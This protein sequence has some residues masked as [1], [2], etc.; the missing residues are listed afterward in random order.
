MAKENTRYDIFHLVVKEL[1]KIFPGKCFD[2]YKK[3]INAFLE[4]TKG[5]NAYRQVAYSLKLMKEIPDSVDRFS[6]YINHIRTKYKRRYALMD[7]I[8]GL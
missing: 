2:L 1:R 4:T 6:R 7:E 8:K 3:K 5:R